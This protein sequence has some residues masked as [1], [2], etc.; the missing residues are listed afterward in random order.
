MNPSDSVEHF[1]V[2]LQHIIMG[3]FGTIGVGSVEVMMLC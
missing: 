1:Q 3:G 2:A